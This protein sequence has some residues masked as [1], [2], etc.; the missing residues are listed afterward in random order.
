MLYEGAA[1]GG[2]ISSGAA[3][4]LPVRTPG[5]I[6]RDKRHQRFVLQRHEQMSHPRHIRSKVPHQHLGEREEQ[7][8][9]QREVKDLLSMHA[10]AALTQHV[11][12][13]SAEVERSEVNLIH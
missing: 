3:A 2:A 12:L 6:Y 13:V 10:P 9:E 11:G 7:E 8:V 4:R 5:P 1:D